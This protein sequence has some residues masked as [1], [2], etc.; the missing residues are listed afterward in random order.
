MEIL[1][2][3]RRPVE[4]VLY[5]QCDCGCEFVAE[6]GDYKIE[7]NSEG[8]AYIS[9]CPYCKKEISLVHKTKIFTDSR[10]PK[11]WTDD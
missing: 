2:Y 6:H 3:G 9:R 5:G 4:L 1:R 11:N 10:K 7:N 8:V